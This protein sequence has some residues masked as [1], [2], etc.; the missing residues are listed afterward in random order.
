M[1]PIRPRGAVELEFFDAA[2]AVV[3]EAPEPED[4][5]AMASWAKAEIEAEGELGYTCWK[6]L[7]DSWGI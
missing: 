3:G 1:V 6:P 4:S 2:S 5:E 7:S